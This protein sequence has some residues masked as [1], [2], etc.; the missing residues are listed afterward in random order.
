MKKLLTIF[1]A[2]LALSV[3]AQEP[4]PNTVMIDL[5]PHPASAYLPDAPLPEWIEFVQKVSSAAP[6]PVE[7]PDLPRGLPVEH[8]ETTVRIRLREL[9][10]PMES[11]LLRLFFDDQAGVHPVVRAW[12]KIG[13]YSFTSQPLGIGLEMLVTESVTILVNGVH[14]I[15]IT[16]P[17]DGSTLRKV[18]LSPL[19]KATA[20]TAVDFPSPQAEPLV[21]P[22]G[23]LATAPA[24]EDDTA[25]YG[26][27]RATLEAGTLKLEPST[28][29]GAKPVVVTFEFTLESAP[30]LACVALEILNADPLA[31]L[32]AWVNDQPV[33]SVIPRYPD[34]ADPAY[35]GQVRPL[36]PMRFHYT[37]WLPAQ[38]VFP[39]GVLKSG[40]NRLTLQ[41]PLAA[42]PAAIRN[43]EL[44]LKHLWRSLDYNIQP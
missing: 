42:G 23:A 17:G 26:R 38:L 15:E 25:L 43:I 4:A 34:L 13:D 14:F 10:E 8:N 1:F 2:V 24:P 21:D 37:A 39:G 27:I 30:L 36:E 19:Q 7:S 44:Q 22:F 12:S 6:E 40:V 5:A 28:E 41:L 29:P 18:F 16:V 9:P 20:R 35:I 3:H 31:P 33:G 11:L 32:Q